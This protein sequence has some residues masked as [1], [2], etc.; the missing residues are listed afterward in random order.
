MK[1]SI[2]REDVGVIRPEKSDPAKPLDQDLPQK[3]SARG[4][5]QLIWLEKSGW[6]SG[7]GRF[8]GRLF[9]AGGEAVRG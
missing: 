4:A 8:L 9:A 6:G 7:I 1:A 5:R 2:G 3:S